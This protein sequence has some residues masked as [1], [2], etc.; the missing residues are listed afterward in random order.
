MSK[1]KIVSLDFNMFVI[2]EAKVSNK[3]TVVLLDAFKQFSEYKISYEAMT[4]DG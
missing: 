3:N 2:L 1:R 4:F